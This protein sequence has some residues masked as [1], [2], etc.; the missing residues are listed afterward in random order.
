MRIDLFIHNAD[1]P[2]NEQ[3]LDRI[4]SLLEI[5]IRKENIMAGE[6]DALTQA[7]ADEETV[8][9]SVITLLGQLS[10]QITAAGTDPAKLSAL[11]TRLQAQKQALADAVVA[12][13]P[14][15]PAA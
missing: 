7:V 14:A 15:A 8:D 12:N 10:A 3:K 5:V 13:T 4:L 11:T 2:A 6:L 1:G 9:A